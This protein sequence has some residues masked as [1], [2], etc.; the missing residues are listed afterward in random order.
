MQ[1]YFRRVNGGQ[2]RERRFRDTD[3]GSRAMPPPPPTNPDMPHRPN[4]YAADFRVSRTQ[5]LPFRLRRRRALRAND[6]HH[7]LVRSGRWL[8]SV[9]RPMSWNNPAGAESRMTRSSACSSIA[10]SDASSATFWL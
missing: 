2:R 10:I 7:F 4:R 1:K 5:H 8:A 3:W 9:S 6:V